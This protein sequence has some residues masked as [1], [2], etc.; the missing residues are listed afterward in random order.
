M[1]NLFVYTSVLFNDTVD[2][3]EIQ[4]WAMKRENFKTLKKIEA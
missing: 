4:G 2:S 3:L 1:R